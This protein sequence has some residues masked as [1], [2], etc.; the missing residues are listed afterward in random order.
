M[1]F[2]L[3]FSTRALRSIEGYY[4]WSSI[5]CVLCLLSVV[6]PPRPISGGT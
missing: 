3:N 1:M 4:L 6:Q 5:S 2:L